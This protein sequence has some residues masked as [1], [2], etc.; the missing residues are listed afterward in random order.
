MTKS[1]VQD[2]LIWDTPGCAFIPVSPWSGCSWPD[3]P[4]S[5]KSD[6]GTNRHH[7][8]S[9]LIQNQK[10][11]ESEQ[12]ESGLDDKPV[13]VQVSLPSGKNPEGLWWSPGWGPPP[14]RPAPPPRLQPSPLLLWEGNNVGW[15]LRYFTDHFSHECRTVWLV[16]ENWLK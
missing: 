8:S 1:R 3:P 7:V 15:T 6:C 11:D 5:W 4:V 16:V 2:R 10:E 13:G 12:E 9:L 14:L